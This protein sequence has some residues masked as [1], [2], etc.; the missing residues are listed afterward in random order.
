M[1]FL[2]VDSSN[3]CVGFRGACL[4]VREALGRVVRAPREESGLGLP[5]KVGSR[6]CHGRGFQTG[7]LGL[8]ASL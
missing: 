1:E 5:L 8:E 7:L 6:V 4:P 2:H 3:V